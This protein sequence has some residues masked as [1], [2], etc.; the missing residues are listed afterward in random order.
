MAANV[1]KSYY[2]WLTVL[3]IRWGGEM[4]KK[5]KKTGIV[6]DV[7]ALTGILIFSLLA[8]ISITLLL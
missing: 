3:M 6:V 5:Q 2:I 7:L 4:G 8:I 1:V